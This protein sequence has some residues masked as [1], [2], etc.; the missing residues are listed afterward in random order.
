MRGDYLNAEGYPDPTAHRAV[1]KVT[2]NENIRKFMPLVYICSRY[3]ADEKHS[4]EENVA[5]AVRYSRFA[6]DQ[7]CIPVTSHLLYPQ[8]LP[9]DDEECRKL[10]LFF[11]SVWLDIAKEIWI[12]SDGGYDAYSE[13]MKAEYKR[14]VK[15]G[16][17]IRRFTED[18]MEV[19]G[20]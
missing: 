14:A 19:Q 16:Y 13:G 1:S 11:G 5:D 9:D 6:V 18:L 4:V 20:C 12:F 10:G 7:G 8:I 2:R 15:K 17:K 3:A